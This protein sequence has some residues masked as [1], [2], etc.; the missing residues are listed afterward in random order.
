VHLI[1]HSKREV[2]SYQVLVCSPAIGAMGLLPW[3]SVAAMS[4][5]KAI[6]IYP[7]LSISLSEL[8]FRFSRSGGPGGQHANR[9]ETRVELL[10]DVGGSSRLNDVQRE[11]LLA[12][13]GHV[14]DQNG[15]SQSRSQYQNREAV[16]ARFRALLQQALR[17]PKKRLL[18]RPSRAARERRLEDKRRRSSRKRYRRRPEQDVD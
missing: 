15:S 7:G 16:V 3:E 12:G 17:P 8:T 1:P 11:R 14:I 4:D 9:S 6:P 13:L 10:F 2:I 18:T 5:E